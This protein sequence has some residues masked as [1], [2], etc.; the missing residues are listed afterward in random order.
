MDR[1]SRILICSTTI[2]P[3][4]RLGR[5]P[6]RQ[7]GTWWRSSPRRGRHGLPRAFS[8]QRRGVFRQLRGGTVLLSPSSPS[9][10]PLR[11]TRGPITPDLRKVERFHQTLRRSSPSS[12]RRVDRAPAGPV[13]TLR[14]YYNQSRPHRALARAR[15]WSRSTRVFGRPRQ[16]AVPTQSVPAGRIDSSGRVTLRYLSVLRHIYV[17]RGASAG[18]RI[19]PSSRTG[20]ALI[21]EDVSYSARHP[22]MRGNYQPLRRPEIVHVS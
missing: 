10:D 8:R 21:R 3:A 5:L 1:R 13:D 11:P 18:E 19:R 16:L 7:A 22:P 12:R 6:A 4:A 9:G 14:A 2:P 15:R 20:C 17:G